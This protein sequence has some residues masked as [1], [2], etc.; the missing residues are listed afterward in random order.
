MASTGPEILFARTNRG[1]TLS[2]RIKDTIRRGSLTIFP[3]E[4]ESKLKTHRAVFDVAVVGLP[5]ERLGER[6]AAAVVLNPGTTLTLEELVEHLQSQ[7]VAKYALPESLHLMTQ[8]PISESP[9]S[10][11]CGWPGAS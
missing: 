7:G 5:D 9:V 4:V 8:L 10:L 3:S 1:M 6:P 11:C 2:G